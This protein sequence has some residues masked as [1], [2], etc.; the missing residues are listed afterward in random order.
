MSAQPYPILEHV[1]PALLVIFRVSG[2]MIFGP[3]FGSRVL[4]PRV[5]VA[6]AVMLGLAVYPA[7]AA[8]PAAPA[9]GLSLWELPGL[10]IFELAI[11]LA[12]GFLASM[13]LIAVQIGGL[14][15]G[16]QM[17]LGFAQFFNPA[18]E[19]E[20]DVLGQ[21]LFYTVLAG[22]LMIGGHEA[23]VLAVLHS[24]DHVPVP[25][26][27]AGAVDLGLINLLTGTMNAVVEMSLRVA[28]PL[29]S[30]IFVQTVALGF[31]A[32]TAPQINILSLGFPMRILVGLFMALAG[33]A[34]IDEVVMGQVN[35]TLDLIFSWIEST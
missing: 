14:V 25:A 28:A 34:V 23:M 17:G 29:L 8:G 21:I 1:S 11:G 10:I 30:V 35:E 2:L 6:L 13:P 27:A 24:F 5:K 22:F 4:L 32:K 31:I 33:L 3:I 20:A 7:L 12:I 19:D 15:M 18:I 26:V 16:Q 9:L